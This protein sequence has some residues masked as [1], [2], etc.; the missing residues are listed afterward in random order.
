[1]ALTREEVIHIATLC[2]VGFSEE[3]L[4]RMQSQLSH[5]LEQFEVLRQIDTERV[6][7]T[8]H[9]VELS[10]VMREDQ[11]RPSRPREEILS[12]APRREED[13]FRVPMVLEEF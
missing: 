5:I 7:P 11:S 13:F 12:N 4:L 8:G 10:T 3:E 1:M 2:R 6:P 9:S